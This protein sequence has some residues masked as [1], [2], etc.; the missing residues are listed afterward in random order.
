MNKM[1]VS[2]RVLASTLRFGALVLAVMAGLLLD[3]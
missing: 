1:P 2:A 3:R